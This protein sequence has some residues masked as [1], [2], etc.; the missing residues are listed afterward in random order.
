MVTERGVRVLFAGGGTGGHLYPAL[1]IAQGVREHAK[2][3]QMPEPA[4]AFVGSEK[5]LEGRILPQ[6]GE[7]F[8]PID[9]QGFHRGSL[10]TMIK[11]NLRF[12]GKLWKSYRRSRQILKEFQPDVVVGTGGYVSGPPLYAAT[13]QGI[14]TLVQ[15][16]N[17]FPGITTRLLAGRVDELHVAYE[18]A[19]NR[20]AKKKR[21]SSR[22][23]RL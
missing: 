1:R 5:G 2:E 8:F 4:I 10:S 22:G 13:R 19:S 17:S 21:P 23:I 11:K 16:Q 7:T 20:L 3:E 6:Q 18:E 9:V 14:P 15:E 12:A